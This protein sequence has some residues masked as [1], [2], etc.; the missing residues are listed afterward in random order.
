ME[1]FDPQAVIAELKKH[2]E[3]TRKPRKSRLTRYASQILLLENEGAS[4]VQIC[5]WLKTKKCVVHPTT[6]SRWL[7][8]YHG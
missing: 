2:R 7:R 6:V 4:Y 1:N 5:L 3:I 8:K